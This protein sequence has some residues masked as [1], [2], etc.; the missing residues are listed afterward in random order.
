MRQSNLPEE[1]RQRLRQARIDFAGY[2]GA[3]TTADVEVMDQL[4]LAHAA[5]LATVHFR[6]DEVPE[7][8]RRLV[9][10][11]SFSVGQHFTYFRE[12]V[13]S[14]QTFARMEMAGQRRIED[15]LLQ[16]Q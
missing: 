10:R 1:G 7:E 14:S 12:A 9:E 4:V 8:L 3:A 16:V 2:Y 5:Y 13:R 11:V 15:L 6:R